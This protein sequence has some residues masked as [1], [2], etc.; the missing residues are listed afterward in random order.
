[1]A[2]TSLPGVQDSLKKRNSDVVAAASYVRN[3]NNLSEA[4]AKVQGANPEVVILGAVQVPC[5]EIL[6][7]A[8]KANWHPLFVLN[9]GSAVDEFV[10]LAGPEAN[11]CLVTEVNPQYVRSDLPTITKYV[12]QLK[13]YYPNEKP[14]FTSLRGYSNAMLWV[15]ALKRTGKDL[16]RENFVNAL[17]GI[18]NWDQV[19]AKAWRSHSVPLATSVGATCSISL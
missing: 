8:T 16:T 18:H 15:E 4:F 19:W 17:E 11:G 5:A 6:K 3:S 9:S 7:M 13:T 2:T 12:N 14:N 1:M 10:K